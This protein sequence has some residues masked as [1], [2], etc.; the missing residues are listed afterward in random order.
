MKVVRL[1]ALRTGSLLLPPPPQVIILGTHFCQK[2]SQPQGHSAAGRIVSMKNFNDPIGYRTRDLP[3]CSAVP[4]PTVACPINI[5][6][7]CLVG[8][9]TE[10]CFSFVFIYVV[11]V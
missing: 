6:V 4:Q 9:Y 2:L 7:V 8:T 3:V 1:S 11:F 5:L 10:L